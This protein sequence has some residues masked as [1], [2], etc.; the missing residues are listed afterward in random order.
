MTDEN[1][2]ETTVDRTSLYLGSGLIALLWLV[3][4]VFTLM[5]IFKSPTRMTTE[6]IGNTLFLAAVVAAVGTGFLA[7]MF[8]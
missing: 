3:V 7:R 1:E 6:D 8:F 4:S 5:L 2:D